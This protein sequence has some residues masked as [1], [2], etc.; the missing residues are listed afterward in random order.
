MKARKPAPRIPQSSWLTDL[1]S[2]LPPEWLGGPPGGGP[3][4]PGGPGGGP[5][6]GGPCGGGGGG[7]W[8]V[9]A[10]SSSNLG[11]LP[12]QKLAPTTASVHLQRRYFGA[13]LPER[14]PVVPEIP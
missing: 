8:N 5:C 4:C 3:H 7:G 10:F 13:E 6:G 12:T 9:M 11:T 1:G 14:L 2:K